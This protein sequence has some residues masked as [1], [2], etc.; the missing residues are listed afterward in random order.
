MLASEPSCVSLFPLYPRLAFSL[1]ICASGRALN[2]FLSRNLT[3]LC[4]FESLDEIC[5]RDRQK[6][7]PWQLI[8]ALGSRCSRASLTA[9][10]REVRNASLP[11]PP[12]CSSNSQTT[13]L[14]T[15]HLPST[16]NAERQHQPSPTSPH[17]Y[18]HNITHLTPSKQYTPETPLH[19]NLK[20]H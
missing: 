11:T 9:Y 10:V 18:L 1:S 3:T 4:V 12:A 20:H 16:S 14:S 7:R 6:P 19:K 17:S 2:I 5:S 8:M 13:S 15:L